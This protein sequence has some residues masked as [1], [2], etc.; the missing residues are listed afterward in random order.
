MMNFPTWKLTISQYYVGEVDS[1]GVLISQLVSKTMPHALQLNSSSLELNITNVDE[2][3]AFEDPIPINSIH[4]VVVLTPM[5]SNIY[6][7]LES[8]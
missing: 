4:L 6:E 3:E 8:K 2:D 7:N 1:C 5:F